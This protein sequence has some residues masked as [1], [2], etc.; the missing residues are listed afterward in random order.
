MCLKDTV[1]RTF[2]AKTTVA[3]NIYKN[4]EI[5]LTLA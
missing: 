1:A 4:I 2:V 3:R 5:V